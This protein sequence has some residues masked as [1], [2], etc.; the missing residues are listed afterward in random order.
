VLRSRFFGA[1]QVERIVA[2]YRSAGLPTEEVALLA[3]AEKVASD[4]WRISAGDVEELRR[5]GFTDPEILDVAMTVGARSFF[6]KVLDA[7]GAEPDGLYDDLEEG[8]RKAMAVG[9]PLER[10]LQKPHKH[11]KTGRRRRSRRSS[12]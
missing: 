5:L 11:V 1:K 7:T 2:D 6:S 3:F 10:K 4:A 12:A 9:R 8:L